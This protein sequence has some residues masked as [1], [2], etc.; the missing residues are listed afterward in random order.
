MCLAFAAGSMLYIVTG[1]LMP[2]ANNLYKGRIIAIGNVIGFIIRN[3]CSKNIKIWLF[4]LDIFRR[5]NSS[6]IRYPINSALL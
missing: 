1:E 4:H 5:E 2:E 6:N 3:N